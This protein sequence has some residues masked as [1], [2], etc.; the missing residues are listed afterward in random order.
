MYNW[1]NVTIPRITDVFNNTSRNPARLF[2]YPWVEFLGPWFFAAIIG[3]L[4]GALFIK[5]EKPIVPVVFFIIC[6]L[7]IM[8]PFV[9]IPTMSS[10]KLGQY[11]SELKNKGLLRIYW[12]KDANESIARLKINNFVRPNSVFKKQ[13]KFTEYVFEDTLIPKKELPDLF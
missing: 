12:N 10:K 8:K 11:T 6:T 13:G 7:L 9:E 2:T 4:A 3:A 5:Y 1:T